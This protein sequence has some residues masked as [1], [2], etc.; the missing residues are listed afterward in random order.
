MSTP[1]DSQDIVLQF[2]KHVAL[3]HNDSEQCSA[4]KFANCP[5]AGACS[6]WAG[7]TVSLKQRWVCEASDPHQKYFR[8]HVNGFKPC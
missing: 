8:V 3:N 6:G 7:S 5:A 4:A 2:Q 1:G